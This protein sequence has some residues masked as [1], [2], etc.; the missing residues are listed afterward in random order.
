[1][2]TRNQPHGTT[3]LGPVNKIVRLMHGGKSVRGALWPVRADAVV[4]LMRDEGYW[5][6]AHLRAL[7]DALWDSRGT[8]SSPTTT[9]QHKHPARIAGADNSTQISQGTHSEFR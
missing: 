2:G 9:T 6:I 1:M 5:S 4:R 8:A 3:Q 7:Q